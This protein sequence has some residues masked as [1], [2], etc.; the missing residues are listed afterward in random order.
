VY[1]FPGE[2][3]H[4][5][6]YVEQPAKRID[7]VLESVAEFA[8]PEYGV[9][10]FKLES[11]MPAASI[12]GE[13]D[14]EVQAAFDELGRLAGRPWVMLSAGATATQFRRVLEHAYRAGASGYLAGRAIWW[15]AFQAF[16]DMDAMRAGLTADGLSYMADLNALTDAEATPW[17]AHPRFGAGGPQ[18]ADAGAGFRHAYGEPS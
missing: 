3:G 16:P 14:P 2:S 17:T 7:H 18:L 6:D 4:T 12:P 1:P 13:D 11:P 10:V 9:D 8:A 15:D 5:T